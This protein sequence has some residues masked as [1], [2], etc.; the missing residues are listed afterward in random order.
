MNVELFGRAAFFPYGHFI[1]QREACILSTLCINIS[2]RHFEQIYFQTLF[3]I[4]LQIL[5]SEERSDLSSQYL[6]C[7]PVCLVSKMS[8]FKKFQNR[9]V[10]ED[11]LSNFD[12]RTS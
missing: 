2:E 1:V 5:V 7:L 9:N 3:S 10:F 11:I 4:L 6:A 8:V 12:F